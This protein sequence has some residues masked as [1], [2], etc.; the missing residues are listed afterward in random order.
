MILCK[1]NQYQF[2]FRDF[3]YYCQVIFSRKWTFLN[4]HVI[5]LN[6]S[7]VICSTSCGKILSA[8]LPWKHYKEPEKKWSSREYLRITDL[9]SSVKKREWLVLRLF[10][11]DKQRFPSEST[12]KLGVFNLKIHISVITNNT[13]T[14]FKYPL[15]LLLD[16]QM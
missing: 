3:Y 9:R 5:F 11:K 6:Y 2:N 10:V 4:I 15:G 1:L 13:F 14:N 16:Y 8:T 12:R 7:L